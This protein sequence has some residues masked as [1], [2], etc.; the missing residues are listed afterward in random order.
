LAKSLEGKTLELHFDSGVVVRGTLLSSHINAQTKKLS[1]LSFK[2][3]SVQQGDKTLFEPEW[4]TYDM[5]VGLG[6][7]NISP[8][9]TAEKSRLKVV[10]TGQE[11]SFRELEPVF[12]ALVGNQ[13]FELVVPENVLP[14]LQEK[15]EDEADHSQKDVS[16][17][18]YHF[19]RAE[20]EAAKYYQGLLTRFSSD[21]MKFQKEKVHERLWFKNY[22]GEWF[23]FHASP[24]SGKNRTYFAQPQKA[25]EL[26]EA[27][28]KY[29]KPPFLYVTDMGDVVITNESFI[30]HLKNRGHQSITLFRGHS[31]FDIHFYHLLLGK[32]DTIARKELADWIRERG[33]APL[34]EPQDFKWWKNLA[35]KLEDPSQPSDQILLQ[36]AQSTTTSMLFTSLDTNF[37]DDYMNRA[38]TSETLELNLDLNKLPDSYLEKIMVGGDE[39]VE[40]VFPY[41][42]IEDIRALRS[43]LSIGHSEILPAAQ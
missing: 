37:T 31:D 24:T 42:S 43:S 32:E 10:L 18:P 12:R 25:Q 17:F 1:I 35:Q 2:D 7:S 8:E 34:R 5:A 38:E 20:S 6:V 19:T 33:F 21:L 13:K 16:Y 40:V 30:R 4:G 14:H 27:V 22:F 36:I 41:T 39:D 23:R 26:V 29:G 11:Q 9:I 3:C 15:T 28:Q